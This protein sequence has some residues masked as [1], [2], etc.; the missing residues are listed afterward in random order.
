MLLSHDSFLLF[1][2]LRMFWNMTLFFFLSPRSLAFSHCQ[3]SLI[4][5]FPGLEFKLLQ[6]LLLMP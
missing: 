3:S 5:E 4:R 6:I 1:F 2:V